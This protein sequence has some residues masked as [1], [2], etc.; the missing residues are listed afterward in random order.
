MVSSQQ[1]D[2]VATRVRA[3]SDMNS[4]QT[5]NASPWLRSQD[6]PPMREVRLQDGRFPCLLCLLP[7]DALHDRTIH[8]RPIRC[9][10]IH[11]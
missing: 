7:Y 3:S 8:R 5:T 2:A 10:R 9:L 1:F 4:D 11:F 6:N